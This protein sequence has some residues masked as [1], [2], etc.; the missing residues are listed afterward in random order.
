MSPC[1]LTREEAGMLAMQN[2][3]LQKERA[4]YLFMFMY[5][6]AA[7][8]KLYI[9]VHIQCHFPFHVAYTYMGLYPVSLNI[10][11]KDTSID[12]TVVSACSLFSPWQG[13][14]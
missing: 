2:Y 1:C 11:P 5:F 12:L 14:V 3:T 13:E 4:Y 9:T 8:K 6:L 10:S 7:E